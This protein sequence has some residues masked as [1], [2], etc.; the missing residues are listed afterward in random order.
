MYY[1]GLDSI[2]T[3]GALSH[4]PSKEGPYRLGVR[5]FG[6]FVFSAE[7]DDPIFCVSERQRQVE[8]KDYEKYGLSTASI[9]DCADLVPLL[10]S[11]TYI[12]QEC[13]SLSD[14]VSELRAGSEK[15]ET[16]LVLLVTPSAC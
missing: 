12:S 10:N 11:C 4:E 6:F 8:T 14:V 5:G 9:F 2:F 3:F 15:K 7:N 16:N 1:R 13:K